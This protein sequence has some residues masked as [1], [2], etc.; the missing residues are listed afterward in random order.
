MHSLHAQFR[1]KLAT[2]FFINTQVTLQLIFNATSAWQPRQLQYSTT[3]KCAQS[4]SNT[5]LLAERM[6]KNDSSSLYNSLV[7]FP[8][9]LESA[10]KCLLFVMSAVSEADVF[11]MHALDND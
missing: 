8:V 11:Q 2:E 4:L 5:V 6:G 9:P 1:A 7:Q 3:R 10:L